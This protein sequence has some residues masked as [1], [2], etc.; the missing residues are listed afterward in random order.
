M[1]PLLE[2]KNFFELSIVINKAHEGMFVYNRFFRTEVDINRLALKSVYE[3][4][5]TFC[6]CQLN[7]LRILVYSKTKLKSQKV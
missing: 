6:W 5:N 3:I 4:I 7:M 1:L 2:G